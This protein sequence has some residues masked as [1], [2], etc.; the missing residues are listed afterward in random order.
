MPAAV[1]RT[2]DVVASALGLIALSPLLLAT[3]LA[4]KLDSK[5]PVFF[6]QVRVGRNGRLFGMLKFRSM[7]PDA[8]K[9]VAQLRAANEQEGPVFKMT[10]DPR[11]TRVGAFIRRYSIDELPQLWNVLVGDMSLVGPRPPI[12]AE[13]AQYQPWQRRR[14]SMRPGITGLW[15]VSGRNAIKFEQWMYLDMQYVDHWSLAQDLRLLL[16]TIPVVVTGRGA[17]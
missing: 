1:K 17:S 11:V 3:A 2:I 10:R 5:G 6:K 16:R 8:D 7:R 14:L 15:Q 13:V 12:P 4:V 9:L